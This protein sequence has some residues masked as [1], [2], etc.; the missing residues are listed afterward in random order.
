LSKLIEIKFALAEKIS[1]LD[2]IAQAYEIENPEKTL[3]EL[4]KKYFFKKYH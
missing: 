1:D 3:W 4:E 2:F